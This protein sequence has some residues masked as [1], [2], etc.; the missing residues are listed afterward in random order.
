VVN[1]I[2]KNAKDNGAECLLSACPLC[3]LNLDMRQ[4]EIERSYKTSYKL[5]VFYFTELMGFAMGF[6]PK[7]LGMSKHFVNP[8]PLLEKKSEQT[9]V[10]RDEA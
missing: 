7:E 10:R 2:L 4:P 9:A 6:A 5:P 3:F 1:S 8:V